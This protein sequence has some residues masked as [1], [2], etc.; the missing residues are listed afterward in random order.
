[1]A[2]NNKVQSKY[3]SGQGIL[4]IAEKDGTTGEPK[5]FTNVGNVSDLKISLKTNT[6]EHKESSTGARGTDFRLTTEI[7]CSV[8][9]LLENFSKENLAIA[10]RGSVAAVVAGT[11]ITVELMAYN[12]KTIALP[13]ANVTID[14]VTLKTPT[15]ALVL[16]TDYTLNAEAGSI[17]ILPGSTLVTAATPVLIVVT[18]DHMAQTHVEAMTEAFMD[19]VLRFEG[20]NTADGNKPVVITIHRFSSD[21][22]KELALITD[23]LGEISL[24]G[25]CLADLTRPGDVS[26]YFSEILA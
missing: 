22:L 13:H 5:G 17:N 10:L 4:L 15:T 9:A 14:T 26:P 12:G 11:A 24:E 3:F 1:M 6:I 8:S 25:S 2:Q 7:G 23:K 18:Y 20:M 21:P 19:Y 16:D